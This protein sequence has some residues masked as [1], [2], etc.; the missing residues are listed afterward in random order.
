VIELLAWH[1]EAA[2]TRQEGGGR[3]FRNSLRRSIRTSETKRR[4]IT[5]PK[6]CRET[7]AGGVAIQ[8]GPSVLRA[9]GSPRGCAARDDG[10]EQVGLAS[11]NLRWN[12]R[13]LLK[14]PESD[15]GIQENPSL[16]ALASLPFSLDSLGSSWIGL[17][18]FGDRAEAHSTAWIG[19]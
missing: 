16:F 13:N 7:G 9:P 10:P 17:G 2:S 12:R 11:Y 4:V 5:R 15:E 18:I 8:M 6:A 19:R 14:S 1:S 3:I